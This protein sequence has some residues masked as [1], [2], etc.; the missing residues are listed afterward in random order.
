MSASLAGY[1]CLLSRGCHN[2]DEGS[3]SE[4]WACLALSGVW[5][6]LQADGFRV[7]PNLNLVWCVTI[8]VLCLPSNVAFARFAI[9]FGGEWKHM[10]SGAMTPSLVLST[11]KGSKKVEPPQTASCKQTVLH[12]KEQLNQSRKPQRCLPFGPPMFILRMEYEGTEARNSLELET[13]W[14]VVFTA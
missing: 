2:C 8:A 1:K 6:V 14:T 11:T 7:L 3:A 13:P 9:H 4:N 5:C 12:L 10:A